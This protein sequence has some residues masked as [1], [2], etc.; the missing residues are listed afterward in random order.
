MRRFSFQLLFCLMCL[1]SMCISTAAIAAGV[2]FTLDHISISLDAAIMW[3]GI[4]LVFG[5]ALHLWIVSRRPDWYHNP[6]DDRFLRDLSKAEHKLSTSTKVDLLG[7]NN[8]TMHQFRRSMP[9]FEQQCKCEAR[10][11]PNNSSQYC[12]SAAMAKR[13]CYDIGKSKRDNHGDIGHN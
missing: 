5:G 11:K 4:C 13:S 9:K 12:A 8:T 2:T 6:S 10:V 3:L 7:F 1:T